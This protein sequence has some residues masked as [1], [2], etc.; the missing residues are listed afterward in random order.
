[1][2]NRIHLTLTNDERNSINSAITTLVDTLTPHM[3]PLSSDER[4]KLPKMGESSLPFVEKVID[5]V[6]S[7]A[8]FNPPFINADHMQVDFNAVKDLTTMMRPL[9]QL[10]DGMS[11]MLLLSGSE[12]YV[13]ALSYYNSV[14]MAHKLN[15][16]ES[17]T[18]YKDLFKRF[19]KQ[20][21]KSNQSLPEEE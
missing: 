2:E 8:Q 17:E 1:M 6:E 21:K 13:A 20:G 12:L 4:K 15:L 10:M 18:I 19:E 11:D 9:E 5:Y 16:P 3:V 14:K 7:D